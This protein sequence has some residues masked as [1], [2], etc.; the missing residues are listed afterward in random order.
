MAEFVKLTAAELIFRITNFEDWGGDL[1]SFEGNFS[2]EDFPEELGIG[3]WEEVEH[4]GGEG[5]GEEYYI[6]LYFKD[7]D[8][9]LREDGYYTSYHGASFEASD[10][11]YEVRPVQ[12]MITF[13]E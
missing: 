5:Q 13:Y 4:V 8:V 3:T 12:R 11:P 9:H 2:P 7:H 10:G 6:V 1:N